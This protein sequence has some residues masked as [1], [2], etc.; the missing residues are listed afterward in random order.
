MT[1]TLDAKTAQF[2]AVTV[3]NVPMLF[4]YG[5]VDPATLPKGV[6]QYAVRHHSEDTKKP[7]QICDWA[8]VN[9]Y[10]SLLS[11]TPLRLHRHPQIK[12]KFKNIDPERDWE[13]RGYHVRLR[14]YLEFYPVQKLARDHER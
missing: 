4:T 10:G 9:R 14:D 8:V 13:T 7:I 2:D 11:T 6:Y 5:Y 1:K 12:S 3:L